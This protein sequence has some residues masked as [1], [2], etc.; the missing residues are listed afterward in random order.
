MSLHGK[1]MA[2]VTALLAS[3]AVVGAGLGLLY[4]PKSGSETRRLV[5]HY[6]KK[7]QVEA[8]RFGRRV[9]SGMDRAMER[10][11]ALIGKKAPRPTPEAA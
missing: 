6:A 4:A 10:G 5:R 11:Q 7:T 9:K 3:G 8:T 1:K 2:T